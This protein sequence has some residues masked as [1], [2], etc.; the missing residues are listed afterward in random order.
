MHMESTHLLSSQNRARLRH[1]RTLPITAWLYSLRIKHPVESNV[2]EV[3]VLSRSAV[4]D[5]PESEAG[6]LAA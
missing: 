4:T 6:R 1:L 2:G 3:I 5:G